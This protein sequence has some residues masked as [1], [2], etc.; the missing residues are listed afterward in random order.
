[1]DENAGPGILF[2]LLNIHFGSIFNVFITAVLVFPDKKE[3]LNNN[4][5]CSLSKRRERIKGTC[6]AVAAMSCKNDAWLFID[7]CF[8]MIMSFLNSS[9]LH[10]R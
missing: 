10:L 4:Q 9:K 7:D 5:Y 1:M 8:G 6:N 3:F 2:W